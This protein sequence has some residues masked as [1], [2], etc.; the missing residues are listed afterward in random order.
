MALFTIVMS[1]TAGVITHCICKWLDRHFL[2]WQ[3]ARAT[4]HSRKTMCKKPRK[5]HQYLRGFIVQRWCRRGT[6][7]LCTPILPHMQ[8]PFNNFSRCKMTASAFSS[9]KRSS[10]R[11]AVFHVHLFHFQM[12]HPYRP[13]G[14]PSFIWNHVGGLGERGDLLRR[15]CRLAFSLCLIVL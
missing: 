2:D 11:C 6:L 12:G 14:L 13:I 5:Y 15:Y 10:R 8:L 1:V 3:T 7:Y 9:P 4:E